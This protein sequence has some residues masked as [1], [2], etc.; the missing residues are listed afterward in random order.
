[1]SK[2]REFRVNVGTSSILLIFVVL[3]LVAFATLSIVSANA[4]YKL[5]RKVADRTTA[6]YAA[7]NQAESYIASIDQTL[8]NVYFSAE[9]EEAYFSTVGHSKSYLVPISDLQSLSIKLDILYPASEEE[10][11]YRITSWQVITTGELEYHSSYQLI[12]ITD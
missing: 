11:F 4:D 10:P 8:Q 2:K 1:M 6:Y 3:C 7:T 12:D 9:S 5:S